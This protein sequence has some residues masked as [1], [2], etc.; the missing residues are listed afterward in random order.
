MDGRRWNHDRLKGRIF[1]VDFWATWCAPCLR[2]LPYL[3]RARA[4]YGDDF[5]ILGISLDTM[6]HVAL[7]RW[8]GRNAVAWPQIHASSGYEDR[9][10]R[11]FGINRLPTNFLL[12]RKG[13]LRAVDVRRDDVFVQVDKLLAEE[14]ATR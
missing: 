9:V 11:S 7:R 14:R 1:L 2:E 13:R 4:R 12:D 8:L 5:E 6:D 10:A 3:K